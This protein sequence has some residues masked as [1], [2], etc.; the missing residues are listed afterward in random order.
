MI[1]ILSIIGAQLNVLRGGWP[2]SHK[3]MQCWFL[4]F[5][6]SMFLPW[7]QGTL[8]GLAM[9]AGA[10]AGGWGA[11]VGTMIGDKPPHSEVKW[12]DTIIKPL[13][14]WPVLWGFVGLTL[15]GG[16]WGLLLSLA[17][18][19]WLPIVAGL[20]MALVYLPMLRLGAYLKTV[21]SYRWPSGKRVFRHDIGW[22][23]AEWIHGFMLW[24]C[25][26]IVLVYF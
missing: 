22:L 9:W 6:C 23:W 20:S 18:W 1:F 11:Y 19:H 14:K 25:C 10:Q 13:E 4:A 16:L 21:T 26:G 5:V 3:W 8:V 15:R 2:V 24:Y 7:W 12:I 17:I